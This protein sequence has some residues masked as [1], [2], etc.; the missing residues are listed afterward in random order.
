MGDQMKD[1]SYRTLKSI[2]PARDTGTGA[3]TATAPE[4]GAGS[5]AGVRDGW[6]ATR[7]G[8]DR[9]LEQILRSRRELPAAA[10]RPARRW[11]WSVAGVAVATSLA[12]AVSAYTMI[13]PSPQPAQAV[14]PP[15]LGYRAGNQSP[16]LVLGRLAAA[17]RKDTS[18]VPAGATVRLKHESWSLSTRVD[19]FQVR[20]A[21]VPEERETWRKPDGTQRWKARTKPPVFDNP[22]E[23]EAWED[24]GAVGEDPVTTEGTSTAPAGSRPAPE[25]APG[26]GKWLLSNH[27]QNSGSGELFDSVTAHH[28]TEFW[29]G[30]QRAALLDLLAARPD[31]KYRGTVTDRSG[32]TGQAVYVDS[33]YGGLP[34]RHTLIFDPANGKLLAYE[35]ELTRTAGALNVKIPSVIMY[36]N[37]LTARAE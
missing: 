18:T 21:V 26:M 11:R 33:D 19:G 25:N 1:H 7:L 13:G 28:L 27:E 9:L 29:N 36:V 32:R 23:K 2:D 30:R 14:T 6:R 20:S 24:S 31:V 8:R 16:Q 22:E 12:L 3:R 5:G 15:A 4:A 37:F 17:A 35:E 34:G 10:P